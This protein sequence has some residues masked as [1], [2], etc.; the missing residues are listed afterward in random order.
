MTE[1]SSTDTSEPTGRRWG[2]AA[3][4]RGPESGFEVRDPHGDVGLI[5]IDR[6]RFLVESE[7]RFATARSSPC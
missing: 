5:Q 2:V 6:K 4:A 3:V 7:F 1:L